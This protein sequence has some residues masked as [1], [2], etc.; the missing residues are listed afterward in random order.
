MD[1]DWY[2]PK[3]WSSCSLNLPFYLKCIASSCYV[4]Y[5]PELNSIPAPPSL[6]L[7]C[8]QHVSQVF[9]SAVWLI[10][11]IPSCLWRVLVSQHLRLELHQCCWRRS[12][13]SFIMLC[14]WS[15]TGT[16]SSTLY[17]HPHKLIEHF[18]K[19]ALV[20]GFHFF[21]FYCVSFPLLSLRS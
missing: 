9:V 13:N 7:T 19:E 16:L 8:R 11:V 6:I 4:K 15:H 14:S 3:V 20:N 5:L 21:F 10:A 2:L 12:G 18:S 17:W 1:V